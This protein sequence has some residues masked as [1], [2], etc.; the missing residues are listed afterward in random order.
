MEKLKLYTWE[1]L[2]A[3]RKRKD[4][5][6]DA[7]VATLIK[8]P[9]LAEEI[10]TWTQ[11]PDAFPKNYP[12]PLV[13][14]LSFFNVAKEFA[15]PEILKVGQQFFNKEGDIYLGLLGFYSL[16]YCYAFG[17][18][19]EVL[20]RSKR[21]VNEIGSRLGE[22]GL[23]VLDLFKPGGF[24][25]DSSPYLTCAKVRLIHAFSRYFILN[26]SNDWS[27]EFGAP[28]NQEDMLG[29]NLAFSMIVL[30]GMTKMGTAIDSETYNTILEY[31]KWIGYLLGVDLKFWPSNAKEAFELDRLIRKR[32]L[33]PTL[34]GKALIT[35]LAA[36]YKE[37]IPD[38]LIRDQ[39]DLLLGFFLG[40]EAGEALGLPSSTKLPGSLVELMF[41]LSGWRNYGSK[42]NYSL[43]RKMM[44]LQHQEQFGKQ[45]EIQIPV[46]NRS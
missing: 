46:I 28:I 36:F 39:V 9:S 14:Y 27:D 23:F 18:G 30:R 44:E 8:N 6:A 29:T 40:K 38:P 25:S 2:D 34:A 11:I 16:P 3:L 4:P 45:F 13:E 10:N 41:K 42:K 7:A 5:L 32:H 15:N 26:F 24:I 35:A 22:T 33:K 20:V 12:Q 19:A 31:W 21:I 17:D 37:N 43:I 1:H